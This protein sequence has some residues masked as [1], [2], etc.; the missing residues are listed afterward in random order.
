MSCTKSVATDLSMV[1]ISNLEGL[2]TELTQ[3]RML[4]VTLEDR[5]KWKEQDESQRKFSHEDLGLKHED[6]SVELQILDAVSLLDVFKDEPDSEQRTSAGQNGREQSLMEGLEDGLSLTVHVN[7]QTT[8]EIQEAVCEN[9]KQLTLHE[10]EEGSLQCEHEAN[11]VQM[12]NTVFSSKDQQT[13]L[14]M[15]SVKLVDWKKMINPENH[16]HTSEPSQLLSSNEDRCTSGEPI[17]KKV[18]SRRGKLQKSSSSQHLNK[19]GKH[20]RRRSCPSSEC[21]RT[22]SSSSLKEYMRIHRGERPLKCSHCGKFYQRSDLKAHQVSHIKEKTYKC[23]LCGKWFSSSASLLQHRRIHT[24]EKPH[25]CPTC[26]KKFLRAAEFRNHQRVHTK[27]KPNQKAWSE[28]LRVH[29][30][31]HTGVKPH[32]CFQ[33]GKAF[34]HLSNLKKHQRVHT[35]EKPYQ[36]SQCGKAFSQSSNLKRHQ[37]IHTGEKPYQCCQCGKAFSQLSNLKTH[38]RVHTGERPYQCSQ[39]GKTFSQ[40]SHLNYHQETHAAKKT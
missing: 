22:C 19:H 11:P 6:S 9:E 35:G 29:Q 26:G 30:T 25:Q 34:S 1:D 33:C 28:S 7:G 27:E 40:L 39:C 21:G 2:Q 17:Q 14:K 3:L 23:A 12:S 5:L 36:C 13:Q 15:C 20:S 37:Q 10:L 38:Q 16:V 32:Q 24:R 18:L 31:I 4:V 8:T